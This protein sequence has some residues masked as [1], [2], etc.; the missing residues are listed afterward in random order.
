MDRTKQDVA[1]RK[2]KFERIFLSANVF[3]LSLSRSERNRI[4]LDLAKTKFER[5]KGG[6]SRPGCSSSLGHKKSTLVERQAPEAMATA[7]TAT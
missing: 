3:K 4:K 5:E 1:N 6:N 2:T 7:V